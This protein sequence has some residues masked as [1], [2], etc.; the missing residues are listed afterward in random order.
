MATSL[1]IGL[2]PI[3]G[4]R[5]AKHRSKNIEGFLTASRKTLLKEA[6][7]HEHFEWLN[8]NTRDIY[9]GLQKLKKYGSV[10]VTTD[11]TNSTRVIQ[12]KDYKRWVSNHLLKAA[13]LALRS[14]VV[15]IKWKWSY[16]FKK[17]MCE[18][19]TRDTSYLVSKAK[20]QISQDNQQ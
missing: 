3:S 17:K 5:S 2:K 6:F 10:C 8:M 1:S 4:F 11:K 19:I 15:L 9:K 13:E 7:W 20:N 12:I 14:K 16:Q 18:T